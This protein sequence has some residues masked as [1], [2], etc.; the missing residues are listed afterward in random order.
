MKARR[1]SGA[2]T[3]AA[4]ATLNLVA[5]DNADEALNRTRASV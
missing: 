1:D 5:R 2:D 3:M 4:R